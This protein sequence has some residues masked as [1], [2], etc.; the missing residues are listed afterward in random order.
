[1][2]NPHSDLPHSEW[3]WSRQG[4][5]ALRWYQIREFM[6]CFWGS[7]PCS[8]LRNYN[9]S[10]FLAHNSHLFINP[11]YPIYSFYTYIYMCVCVCVTSPMLFSSKSHGF[12][13]K[14]LEILPSKDRQLADFPGTT[15]AVSP[16]SSNM[17]HQPV[18]ISSKYTIVNVYTQYTGKFI[19]CY[20]M[21][22]YYVVLCL[23]LWFVYVVFM[24]CWCCVMLCYCY[25]YDTYIYMYIYIYY[26][27]DYII[28]YYVIL[29]ICVW[30]YM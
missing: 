18:L 5:S 14:F 28:L 19:L 8:Y 13:L 24:L 10:W 2:W 9:S 20:I 3:Q 12:L 22:E 4:P 7:H 30:L 29:Y 26:I 23:C 21:L 17:K 16:R 15:M 25:C 11:I 27:F 6:H 1:M